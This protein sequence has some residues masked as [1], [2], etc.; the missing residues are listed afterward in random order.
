[1]LAGLREILVVVHA[2]GHDFERMVDQTSRE[3]PMARRLRTIPGIGPFL[4]LALAVEIGDINRF[5]DRHSCE[6][7]PVLFQL[8]TRAETRTRVGRSLRRATS[9]CAMPQCWRLSGSARRESPIR[10]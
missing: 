7:T 1:M 10:A 3:H 6:A 4:S 2:K 8:S 9:G 5:L